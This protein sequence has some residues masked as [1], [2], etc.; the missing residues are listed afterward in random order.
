MNSRERAEIRGAHNWV[1]NRFGVNE[2]PGDGG[3]DTNTYPGEIKVNEVEIDPQNVFDN[4]V[5]KSEF[6]PGFEEDGVAS[7]EAPE[8]VTEYRNGQPVIKFNPGVD[9][10]KGGHIPF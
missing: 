1:H 8:V 10:T 5:L 9:F 4:G 2:K 7:M 6:Q 3:V